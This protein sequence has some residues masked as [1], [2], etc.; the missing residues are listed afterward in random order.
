MTDL[1][2]ENVRKFFLGAVVA[3]A[4]MVSMWPVEARACGSCACVTA[5]HLETR[6]YIVAWHNA[7]RTHITNE[8]KYHQ[9]WLMNDFFRLTVGP[10]LQMMTEQLVS[11]GMLQIFAVGTFFDAKEQLETQGLMQELTAQAHK[12]YQPST[13]MC[14]FGTA[15]RSLAGAAR[16]A[17]LAAFALNQRSQDRQFSNA[18]TNSSVG[19]SEDREGRLRHF[20]GR[21]CDPE[22]N[23]EGFETLCG[24]GGSPEHFNDDVDF[25]GTFSSKETLDIDFSDTTDSDDEQDVFALRDN[26]YAHD[27]MEPLSQSI[28][29]ITENQQLVFDKRALVARRGVAE[30]SFNNITG[31]KMEG[32]GASAE[33]G[34]FAAVLLQQMGVPAAETETLIGKQPSYYA[35]I[36]TLGQTIYQDPR[37]FTG[38]YDTPANTARKEVAMQ[39]VGLMIDRDAFLS[40]L[41]YEAALSG[42]LET[43]VAKY[44]DAAQ[45]RAGGVTQTEKKLP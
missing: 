20:I 34:K 2:H 18:N 39:A 9:N 31:M 27:I 8:F 32:T 35:M 15:A 38:L 21:Y 25:T 17:Q 45:N 43:E 10:A 26:L 3:L 28:I 5:A 44:Q 29:S 12:D 36:E 14:T 30:N 19:P 40:E 13:E 23:M 22:D 24:T 11:T 42:I 37:F 1:R 41:R 7:T 4:F 16:N 6:A 33:T